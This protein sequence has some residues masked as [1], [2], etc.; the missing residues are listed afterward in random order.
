M[1][2]IQFNSPN[3]LNAIAMNPFEKYKTQS[4]DN[5]VRT[6][7]ISL[8]KFQALVE[9]IRT[10]LQ[11]QQEHN[12]LK[13][14]GLKSRLSLENQMLLTLLYLRDYP[15]FIKLGLQFGISESYASKIYHKIS[16]LLVKILHVKN[17]QV[18]F[19]K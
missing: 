11:V 10:T 13:K 9:L 12:R 17:R 3:Y 6:V 15:T 4:A 7:G 18:L 5:F 8:D 14:R 2:Q 16:T 19:G 1:S